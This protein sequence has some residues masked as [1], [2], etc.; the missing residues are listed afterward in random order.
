MRVKMDAPRHSSWEVCH[1]QTIC[2]SVWLFACTTKPVTSCSD[3]SPSPAAWLHPQNHRPSSRNT[4]RQNVD[5]NKAKTLVWSSAY[6]AC[7]TR[8][9]NAIITTN[10]VLTTW[11]ALENTEG[12]TKGSF[13][14]NH[15]NMLDHCDRQTEI[16]KQASHDNTCC[17]THMYQKAKNSLNIHRH[18]QK[19][20][21]AMLLSSKQTAYRLKF[22]KIL[23]PTSVSDK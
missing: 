14:A 16:E 12:Y 21:S 19:T 18:K 22:N 7:V 5:Y 9:A 13:H 20:L 2:T 8:I 4:Q 15:S 23:Q 3:D 17:T 6:Y 11:V 10:C 1:R